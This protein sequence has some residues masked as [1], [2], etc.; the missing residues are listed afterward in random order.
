MKEI[1]LAR[2]CIRLP[3]ETRQEL[4]ALLARDGDSISAFLR[5]TID[6]KTT[7]GRDSRITLP[8]SKLPH[9]NPKSVP[10]ASKLV[11]QLARKNDQEAN[12]DPAN[13]QPTE[14]KNN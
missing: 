13:V 9:K 2:I 3:L 1:K 14:Q 7:S 5:R 4:K 12:K 8:T 11:F 10:K 6:S